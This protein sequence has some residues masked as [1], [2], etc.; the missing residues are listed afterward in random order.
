MNFMI[1]FGNQISKTKG[2]LYN[3]IRT[4]VVPLGYIVNNISLGN[5]MHDFHYTY[6]K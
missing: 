1:N 6:S 3:N 5:S 4:H 2:A